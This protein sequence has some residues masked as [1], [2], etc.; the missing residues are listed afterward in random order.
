MDKKYL[1]AKAHGF[2][3]AYTKMNESERRG[4]PRGVYGED[5]N[6]LRDLVIEQDPDLESLLPP[7]VTF[8]TTNNSN[9]TLESFAIINTFCEQI[10]Q[11]LTGIDE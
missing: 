8:Y 3:S 1:A 7:A 11:M 6:R 2:T 10:S 5:Y 9:W 4:H